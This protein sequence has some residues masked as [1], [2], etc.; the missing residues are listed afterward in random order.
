[1]Y[2]SLTGAS[3]FCLVGVATNG[4]IRMLYNNVWIHLNRISRV[5][6]L[7]GECF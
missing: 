7:E 3:V 1:M 2:H 6:N 4:E 5:T